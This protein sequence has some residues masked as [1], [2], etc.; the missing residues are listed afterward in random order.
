[1]K[2]KK[3]EEMKEIKINPKNKK[4]DKTKIKIEDEKV[5]SP[6]GSFFSVNEKENEENVK[7]PNL[8]LEENKEDFSDE[9]EEV[10]SNELQNN[11]SKINCNLNEKIPANKVEETELSKIEKINIVFSIPKKHQ[12]GLFSKGYFTYEFCAIPLKNI[13]IRKYSDF[14][15]LHDIF[16]KIYTGSCI[17]PIP[18]NIKMEKISD[19]VV[20]KNKRALEKFVQGLI[21]HPLI[22]HSPILFDFLSIED[23]SQFYARQTYYSKGKA[24]KSLSKLITLNGNVD[25]NFHNSDLPFLDFI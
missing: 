7:T 1:M 10:I 15:W 12:G 6:G 9:K 4:I 20:N 3:V 2:K 23:K 14:K 8:I 13:V 19:D 22:K 16:Q 17:P 25:I 11:I 18:K 5:Q 24:P 21:D